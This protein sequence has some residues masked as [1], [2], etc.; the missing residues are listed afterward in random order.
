MAI[1][2]L[3]LGYLFDERRACMLQVPG[4]EGRAGM[5]AIQTTGQINLGRR[6][7]FASF[8]KKSTK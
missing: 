1:P 7:L 5:A 8:N 3:H 4:A 2:P 6:Y